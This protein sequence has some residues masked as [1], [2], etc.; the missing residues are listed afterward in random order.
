MLV[1]HSLRLASLLML[2]VMMG[3]A[4]PATDTEAQVYSEASTHGFGAA[5]AYAQTVGP[6]AYTHTGSIGNGHTYAHAMTPHSYADSGTLTNGPAAAMAYSIGS[7]FGS[8]AFTQV[9]SFFGG[10][11]SGFASAYP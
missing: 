2:V 4:A 7:P 3:I 11:A 5:F 10:F 8:S 1:K 6:I 9:T